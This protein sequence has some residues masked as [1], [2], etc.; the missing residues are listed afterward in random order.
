MVH[1]QQQI[2]HSAIICEQRPPRK[3]A[4]AACGCTTDYGRPLDLS[5]L[6]KLRAEPHSYNL[7]IEANQ[8]HI[9]FPVL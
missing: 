6:G 5:S 9:V 7:G 1:L 2:V 8:E 3:E 4:R